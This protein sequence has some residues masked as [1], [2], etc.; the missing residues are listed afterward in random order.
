MLPGT[1]P[2]FTGT[3][4]PSPLIAFCRTATDNLCALPSRAG[5]S[6]PARV[7]ASSS[8]LRVHEAVTLLSRSLGTEPNVSSF[9]GSR[10]KPCL[11]FI[12]TAQDP[13]SLLRGGMRKSN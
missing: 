9:V 11:R 7:P 2:G 6:R 3:L 1:F 10:D 8:A 4:S 12:K 13:L 5:S